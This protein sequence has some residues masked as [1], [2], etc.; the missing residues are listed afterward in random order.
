[1][2]YVSKLIISIAAC[3][4]VGITGEILSSNALPAWYDTL[5][6]PLYAPPGWLFSLVWFTLFFLTG[7]AASIIWHKGLH[8]RPI[9]TAL[10]FF[11]IMLVL[12]TGWLVVFFSYH[13]ILYGIIVLAALWIIMILTTIKF[14]NFSLSGGSLMIPYII[15][16]TYL[17]VVNIFLLLLNP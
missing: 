17:V 9:K 5:Q 14:Y 6:K 7:I 11:L 3:E 12:N 16:V 13:F 2:R 1:M 8:I 10:L 15:W 4:I